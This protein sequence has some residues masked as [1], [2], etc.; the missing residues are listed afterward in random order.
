VNAVAFVLAAFVAMWAL[1]VMYLAVMNLQRVN[2]KTPLTGWTRA[3]ANSVYF[4][5][6]FLDA[7][8]NIVVMTIILFE[9]P[10]EWLVTPRVTRLKGDP[11]WRGDVARWFC[12][13][14]L[15]P[16]DPSGCHCK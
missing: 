1:W 15:D 3:F 10:R 7:L 8:A 6:L 13:T 4:P 2:D 11:G 12:R 9:L 5:G 14:L 16:F